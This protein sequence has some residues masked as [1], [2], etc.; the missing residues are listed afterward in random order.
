MEV[1]C[2]NKRKHV[3]ETC[4][5]STEHRPYKSQKVDTKTKHFFS[6][7]RTQLDT[8][9][10]RVSFEELDL[11]ELEEKYPHIDPK[12]P[13]IKTIIGTYLNRVNDLVVNEDS[14]ANNLSIAVYNADLPEY[15]DFDQFL[16]TT[17]ED[18]LHK[19]D[20]QFDNILKQELIQK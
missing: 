12:L 6:T 9:S 1:T 4:M 17:I 15:Y 3:D 5:F 10:G 16:S 14:F 18:V 2:V 11:E 8:Y 13:N 20:L 19:L 7:I